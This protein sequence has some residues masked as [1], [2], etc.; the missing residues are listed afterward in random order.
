[1][2]M[3]KPDMPTIAQTAANSSDALSWGDLSETEKSAASLGVHPEHWKPIAFM[4]DAHYETLLKANAIGGDL[5][6]KLEAFK[7]VAAGGK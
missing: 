2:S 5:A 3:R 4:N 1:M 6:K 7:H